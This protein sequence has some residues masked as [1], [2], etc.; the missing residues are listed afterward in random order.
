MTPPPPHSTKWERRLLAG[1]LREPL[2]SCESCRRHGVTEGDLYAHA[3]RLVWDA[4]WSLIDSG[5]VPDLV[6][7]YQTLRCRGQLKELDAVNPALWLAD[8][9]DADPTG[10]WCE[11]ACR[12]VKHKAKLRE[13]IHV[14]KEVMAAAYGGLLV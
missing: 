14:A 8:L 10:A 6:G 2:L 13:Q 12:V 11:F 5:L 4:V 7:V 9:Y 3:H 1:L